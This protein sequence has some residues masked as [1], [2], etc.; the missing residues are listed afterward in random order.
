MPEKL[1]A[2]SHAIDMPHSRHSAGRDVV[3]GSIGGHVV[4]VAFSRWR[5]VAAA[6]IAAHLLTAVNPSSVII[7]G[8]AGA[9]RDELAIGDQV[10]ARALFQQ[11][12]D[13]SPFFPR[14]H[15]PLL[16]VA[17]LPTDAELTIRCM[18][19]YWRAQPARSGRHGCGWAPS[20]RA[21]KSLGPGKRGRGFSRRSQARFV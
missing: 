10:L 2:V 17:A 19:P 4:T 11:D 13:A 5:K 1:E 16:N 20:R 9:L 3:S 6:S 8:I 7:T 12:L 15:V 18:A 14:T 21:I